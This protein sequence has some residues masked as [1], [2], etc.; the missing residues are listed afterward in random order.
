MIDMTHHN[1]HHAPALAGRRLMTTRDYKRVMGNPSEM[2]LWR[3]EQRGVGPK[4]VRQ[5][6]R[7]FWFEDE[8]TA[9]LEK[10]AAGRSQ[11]DERPTATADS[12][13]VP[14]GR[15]S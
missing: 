1:H 3:D 12:M 6:G 15:A 5:N 10:L 14:N 9:Y 8:V 11:P 2:K 4:P 7:R 13:E